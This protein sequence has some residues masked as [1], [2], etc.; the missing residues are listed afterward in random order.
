MLLLISGG[1][2]PRSICTGKHV[3]IPRAVIVFIFIFLIFFI[4]ILFYFIQRGRGKRKITVTEKTIRSKEETGATLIHYSHA[5]TP[6]HT[7][8]HIHNEREFLHLYRIRKRIPFY[9]RYY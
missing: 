5:Q 3:L 6:S 8:L 9:L 1:S 2:P 7:F 4:I